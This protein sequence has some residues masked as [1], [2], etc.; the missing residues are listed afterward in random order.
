MKDIIIDIIK[1]TAS[2]SN[3]YLDR[4]A[5][6]ES[7]IEMLYPLFSLR[8]RKI[9]DAPGI[10]SGRSSRA[11]RKDSPG[12]KHLI[13]QPLTFNDDILSTTLSGAEKSRK[14]GE[15][16]AQEDWDEQ[17]TAHEE[18]LRWLDELTEELEP[19]KVSPEKYGAKPKSAGTGI[20][21]SQKGGVVYSNSE[22]ISDDT[23]AA[24]DP[25]AEIRPDNSYIGRHNKWRMD[26]EEL[27]DIKEETED[28]ISN[29]VQEWSISTEAR[30][31]RRQ[32]KLDVVPAGREISDGLYSLDLKIEGEYN[33]SE[34]YTRGQNSKPA[35]M[36]VK[37]PDG[38]ETIEVEGGSAAA[39]AYRALDSKGMVG[40]FEKSEEGDIEL[41]E[42]RGLEGAKLELISSPGGNL[43][44]NYR[45]PRVVR[46]DFEYINRELVLNPESRNHGYEFIR[47]VEVD[48]GRAMD[49]SQRALEVI[50]SQGITEYHMVK[51][52][53]AI[54]IMA[55][56]ISDGGYT[57]EI[58]KM[59]VLSNDGS[60]AEPAIYIKNAY[61]TGQ[62]GQ[63]QALIT[64]TD[65]G[66][67]WVELSTGRS[68]S[69]FVN[70]AGCSLNLE[71]AT[72]LPGQIIE[73]RL[74]VVG[75]YDNRNFE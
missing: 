22:Y 1:M 53:S 68:K 27:S 48:M 31:A 45:M 67:L 49:S 75:R 55:D 59:E 4:R 42:I 11:P 64:D 6:L 20:T 25:N 17:D 2:S 7:I 57:P 63:R 37:T 16:R 70:P 19:L 51:N 12:Y 44:I 46:G 26:A 39:R 5:D 43:E 10:P 33:A 40:I 50:N 65:H 71:R 36:R 61:K 73:A 47:P 35:L 60:S 3:A 21:Y 52:N 28:Y 8:L 58:V 54:A 66:G 72:P 41:K 14:T 13:Y 18:I 9:R 62:D 74:G 69:E 24:K 30:Q 32:D 34:H 29:L 23:D 56:A 15:L 38:I